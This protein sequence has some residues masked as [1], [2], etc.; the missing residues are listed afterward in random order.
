M[1]QRGGHCI[2]T[3]K[4]G[5]LRI[6][7]QQLMRPGET[8]KPSIRGTVKLA[9]LREREA[10]SINAQLFT[11]LT[12]CRWLDSTWVDAVKAGPNGAYTPATVSVNTNQLGIGNGISVPI[13]KVFEQAPL[14]IFNEWFKWP[15]NADIT[16]WPADGE[17]MVPLDSAWSR[18][19][20]SAAPS[21][22]DDYTV[23]S[24][25]FDVRDLAKIQAMFRHSMENEVFAFGRYRD[26][27][28]EI[29]GADASREVDQVPIMVD[30][31]NAGIDAREMP[32]TDSAGLGNWMTIYDFDINHRI[33]PVTAPEH[34][35]LTYALGV[36][37]ESVTRDDCNYNANAHKI[38]SYG[39]LF[40]DPGLMAAEPPDNVLYHQLFPRGGA[41]SIGYLSA[42]WQW[43]A[44]WNHIGTR[45]EDRQSFPIYKAP[46]TAASLRDASL[47]ENAFTSQALG[48]YFY[49]LQ[50]NEP[51]DAA[52]PSS[53]R[54]LMAGI[55]DAGNASKQREYMG[56]QVR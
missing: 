28:D 1:Y 9:N 52:M 7:R 38:P 14:R 12:P 25:A 2:A 3:G 48:D 27:M 10:A 22:S 41:V 33:G 8:I 43:R 56:V 16:T 36:R 46:T 31:E 45:V 44:P 32:A 54:S 39:A 49:D 29:W 5:R 35:V 19:R 50:F 4:I 47:I 42:G 24:G 26:L 37:F 13:L 51:S 55:G 11:F 15:E 17:A 6:L 21:D 23:P 30:R 34:C 53:K 18:V 40:G 20:D